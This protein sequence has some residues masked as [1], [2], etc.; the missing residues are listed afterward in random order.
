MTNTAVTSTPQH[1]D[2]EMLQIER[3]Q[4]LEVMNLGPVGYFAGLLES[5]DE[6]LAAG[7]A[8]VLLDQD[9]A[10]QSSWDR[11]ISLSKYPSVQLRAF[12]FFIA[13]YEY[14]RA[15][16]VLQTPL[17]ADDQ[18]IKR[19]LAAIFDVDPLTTVEIEI[20]RF[21]RTGETAPIATAAAAAES[22]GGWRKALPLLVDLIL[23]NPQNA[24][25]P[26]RLGRALHEANRLDLLKRFC[27]IV[28]TIE[29]FPNVSLIFRAAVAAQSGAAEDG[30]KLLA[31]ADLRKLPGAEVMVAGMKA[32]MFE[33]L[34]RIDEA[35][36]AYQQQNRLLRPKDFKR[37]AFE[38]LVRAKGAAGFAPPPPDDRL[39]HL[40]MLGFPRSGTTLL[41]NVLAGHPRIETFEEIPSF[42]SLNHLFRHG[43]S[44]RGLDADFAVKARTRYY[45]EIDRRKKKAGADIFIDKLPSLSAEAKFLHRLF[46]E[47]RYIFS[48]RHPYDVVLS[49]FKQAFGSNIAMDCFTSFDD[50][51]RV[52][53]FSMEQWFNQY[54]LDAPE[55]C[56]VRYERLVTDL[57]NEVGR[58][59]AFLGAEWH[60]SVLKF[61]ERAEQ[62]NVRTPS[63]AKVRA[64][65]SIGVQTSWRSYA[66][67]FKTR[68]ARRLDRWVRHF[69]YE[70]E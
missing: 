29:I 8:N 46:P 32:A 1:G 11:I 58:A 54:G 56:Y 67:L 7:A 38:E 23:I 20:E 24:E 68:E 35:Y 4:G 16:A 42:T 59:L 53:D 33:K 66:F 3:L 64:G 61:A 43:R 47:K 2:E 5:G 37:G 17:R 63:Y 14:D 6:I 13:N 22:A 39:N 10:P 52:Y 31:R 55:V 36:A 25:W 50:A 60:A 48:V 21:Y 40:I 28:D 45:C 9:V 44:E 65:L 26:L 15:R 19:Q 27:D 69:G 34:G 70:T 18:L 57:E 62:R 30:L 41:E 49:C 12:D 51:C